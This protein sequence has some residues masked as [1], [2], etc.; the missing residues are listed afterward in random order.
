MD[1]CEFE[2]NLV[3]REGPRLKTKENKTS[4][5]KY[6]QRGEM[7]KL[8]AREGPEE[9][10]SS[11]PTCQGTEVSMPI[12]VFGLSSEDPLLLPVRQTPP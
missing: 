5:S 11:N 2:G 9:D 6:H 3:Y 1:L 4:V 12:S 8:H 10:M 7:T